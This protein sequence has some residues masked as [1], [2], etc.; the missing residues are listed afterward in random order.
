MLGLKV[1]KNRAELII[2]ITVTVIVILVIIICLPTYLC[3][4]LP[5]CALHTYDAKC[6]EEC[7][8]SL[9]NGSFGR[10]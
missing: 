7:V 1:L 5:A 6:P 4:C 3:E 10:L 8:K 9:A 2:T